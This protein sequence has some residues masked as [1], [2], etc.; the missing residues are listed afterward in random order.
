MLIR[1]GLSDLTLKS[2]NDLRM[3]F[4]DFFLLQIS[5]GHGTCNMTFYIFF[6]EMLGEMAMSP[7]MHIDH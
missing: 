2:P 3:N 6:F 1:L 7:N 4:G 5:L